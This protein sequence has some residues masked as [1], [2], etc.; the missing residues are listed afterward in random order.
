MPD[1]IVQINEEV[2]IIEI[3]SFGA[4]SKGDIESSISK[5]RQINNKTGIYKVIVN[6]TEQ[7][8]MPST[9]GIFDLFSNFPRD[10]KVAL[11]IKRGQGTLGDIHFCEA[12]AC[13]RASRVKKFVSRDEALRWLEYEID[14]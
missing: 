6:T 8:S 4:V 5:V 9:M 12:V 2:G 11:L 7:D 3:H 14:I 13:N 10:L 1:K